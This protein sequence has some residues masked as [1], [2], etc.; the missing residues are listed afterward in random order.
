M[1]DSYDQGGQGPVG[2]AISGISP[3][4]EG[5]SHHPDSLLLESIRPSGVSVGPLCIPYRKGAGGVG[6]GADQT[7]CLTRRDAAGA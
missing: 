4:L 7:S 2:A 5:T 1:V 3:T 6:P